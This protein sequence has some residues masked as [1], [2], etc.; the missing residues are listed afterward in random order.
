MTS[1]APEPQSSSLSQVAIRGAWFTGVAQIIRVAVQIG[2]VIILA[3]LLS[4]ADFG[5]IA[6]VTPIVAFVGLFQEMGLSQ[7]VVQKKSI[8]HE[9]LSAL[10]WI[11]L[12]LAIGL[13]LVLIAASPVVG[14][15]YRE[16]D[17]I[18]ITAAYGALIIFSSIGSQANA[19]LNRK[20]MFGRLAFL[21]SAGAVVALLASAAF[22][23]IIGNYWA[24]FIGTL[25]ATIFGAIGSLILAGWL[26]GRFRREESVVEL[27]RFGGGITAFNLL[28]FFVRNGDSVLIGRY[29]GRFS[30][31]LYD[32]AY[33]LLLMPMQLVV[34]PFS[35]I[36]IPIL[37]NVKDDEARY[38]A[39]YTRALR[40]LLI[41][42]TP[43]IAFGA[44][45]AYTL[46]PFLLGDQ[47]K[48]AAPIFAALGLA[49][50]VQS[51]NGTS[52]WL[53]ISQGRL[54]HYLVAGAVGAVIALTA[55]VL[56]LSEGAVGVA[57]AYAISEI[58]KTP[59]LW[60]YITRT[61]PISGRSLTGEVTPFFL[62]FIVSF[63]LTKILENVI[64]LP[65]FFKLMLSVVC[66][67]LACFLI[68]LL[69]PRGRES[70]SELLSVTRTILSKGRRTT[71]QDKGR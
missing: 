38:G 36:M 18:G 5:I 56:G 68:L 31:G 9:E 64:L 1:F 41:L 62:S 71:H 66:A 27:L 57:Q 59:L 13:G 65:V 40:Q 12:A 6:M 37:S 22:A 28:N 11:N 30:L 44:A 17:V 61:G 42:T 16:P 67:Y 35:K 20:M 7:A 39:A 60:W 25:F 15:Y 26:P 43:A 10:F 47:W 2:S 70:L 55:F 34:H 24:L 3:R 21:D 19:L 29:A 32:R 63:A 52:G 8:T 53:L 48:G 33:K 69:H 49:A 50:S 23:Y 51:L 54:R 58:V 46:I 14:M 45:S 4:P